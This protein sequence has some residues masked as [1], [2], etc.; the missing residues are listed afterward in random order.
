MFSISRQRAR[1]AFTLVELLVVIA[2]IGILV[3]LL[4]PAVQA[5][6]EAARRM[7]CQN[8]L[9][10]LGLAMHNFES[11]NRKLPPGYLG[12]TRALPY[13]APANNDQYYGMLIFLAPYMELSNI[14]QQMPTALMDVKRLAATGEDIRWSATLTTA[15]LGSATQPFSLS[16]YKIPG[17]MCPSDAKVPTVAWTRGH[18]RTTSATATGLTIHYFNGTGSFLN[19]ARTNYLGC[20]GRPDVDGGKREGMFRNRSETKFSH[21]Q[22]GLSNTLAIGEAEGGVL[23]TSGDAPATWLWMSAPTLPAS[24]TW[25]V[26]A[27]DRGAFGSYHT[28][29]TQF[30][31]GDGSV[32]G[33]SDSIDV[34]TWVSL[35][36]MK[37][38]DVTTNEL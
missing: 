10:Q 27:G 37:D 12:P 28:G 30:V 11:A 21:V 24:G 36:G 23:A 13:D 33:I 22:D 5:A 3:G 4:L 29:I 31:V 26:G 6:R 14:S 9:K 15:L 35:N 17:F 2:I 8:N 7:S 19:A 38:G 25:M 32:R 20:H 1:D 34:T 16:Q 18:V